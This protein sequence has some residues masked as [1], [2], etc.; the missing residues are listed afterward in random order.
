MLDIN[1][2]RANLNLILRGI[3][4]NTEIGSYLGFKGG[5]ACLMLYGLPRFSVDLDLNLMN[6]NKALLVYEKLGSFLTSK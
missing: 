2:H 5:T 1:K 4:T 6:P 3:Y